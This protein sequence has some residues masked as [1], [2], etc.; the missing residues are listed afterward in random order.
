MWRLLCLLLA[1]VAPSQAAIH[2]DGF[3]AHMP[4]TEWRQIVGPNDAT[5]SASVLVP[6]N[7]AGSINDTIYAHLFDNGGI[8]PDF[9]TTPSGINSIVGIEFR[10]RAVA[11]HPGVSVSAI[12]WSGFY[13]QASGSTHY[14]YSQSE[15]SVASSEFAVGD[16]SD[17]SAGHY[18]DAGGY[19]AVIPSEAIETDGL[20]SQSMSAAEFWLTDELE[21]PGEPLN[22]YVLDNQNW[23]V[24]FRST[25]G[26]NATLYVDSIHV[27]LHYNDA[28]T[29][30][31]SGS[32][33][34]SATLLKAKS[35]ASAMSGSG[36]CAATL[37]AERNIYSDMIGT[38]KITPVIS[39]DDGSAVYRYLM[40][41]MIG[42]G[43]VTLTQPIRYG[44]IQSNMVGSGDIVASISHGKNIMA[45][46]RNGTLA[47]R[48]S[49][50]IAHTLR[51]KRPI[52]AAISGSGTLSGGPVAR[53]P[54]STAL[55]GSGT[56]SAS[57]IAQRAI[58]SAMTGSGVMA[59]TLQAGRVHPGVAMTG[60]GGMSTE[61]LAQRPLVAAMQA[62]GLL[63]ADLTINSRLPAPDGRTFVVPESEA[64]FIAPDDFLTFEAQE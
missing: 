41:E 1:F 27:R 18:I 32:G 26:Y 56:A 57:M 51:A 39:R 42:T 23:V 4:V 55:A 49:G 6:H 14:L 20:V 36:A 8:T 54:I 29:A 5:T 28:S 15:Q 2:Y 30:A 50:T 12:G 53:R 17:L 25:G 62:T 61:L 31:M 43:V 35:M 22:P 33:T 34:M 21:A 45:P 7:S 13:I 9:P 44:T 58:A 24:R 37:N 48:G 47:L 40:P 16:E 3:E 59:E 64:T 60:A 10:I 38:G 11:S 46:S 63:S 52:V 19:M